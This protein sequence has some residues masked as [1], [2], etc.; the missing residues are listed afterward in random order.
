MKQCRNLP[1][2][3]FV[4]VECPLDLSLK[5]LTLS[6]SDPGIH[7]LRYVPHIV[8]GRLF[9]LIFRACRILITLLPDIRPK[10]LDTRCQTT[11]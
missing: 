3:Q 11:H 9:V 4:P 1:R 2:S 10:E 8:S 7:I 6:S 5:A